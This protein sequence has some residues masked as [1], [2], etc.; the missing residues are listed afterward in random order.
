MRLSVALVV[1]S[2]AL[3]GC[4]GRP[5]PDAGGIEIYQQLC[6]R[7]HGEDLAGR[8]GPALG[9]GSEI[10]AESDEFIRQT[11]HAGRGRMPSFSRTL[12]DD[13]IER[14]IAYLREVQDE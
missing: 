9:P 8:I 2:V 4:S 5:A 12:T 3:A 11:I 7:C 14:V 10:A 13:Q 1:C 6:A